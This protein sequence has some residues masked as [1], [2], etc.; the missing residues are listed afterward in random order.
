MIHT[1][2]AGD[3]SQTVYFNALNRLRLLPCE[4]TDTVFQLAHFMTKAKIP[5][6]PMSA[7]IKRCFI[8][9]AIKTEQCSASLRKG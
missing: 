2:C 1:E 9:L 5:L 3:K 8:L 4:R 7:K 6:L